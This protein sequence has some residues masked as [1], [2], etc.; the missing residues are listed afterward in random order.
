MTDHPYKRNTT[1]SVTSDLHTA[2]RSRVL[3]RNL[4]IPPISYAFRPVLTSV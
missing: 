1:K 2:L 3:R 4:T